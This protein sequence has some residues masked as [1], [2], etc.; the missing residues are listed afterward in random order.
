MKKHQYQTNLIW[1]GNLGVGT[2]NYAAYS[3]D[4]RLEVL[5]KAAI[6][7]SSDPAFKG[8][9]NKHNPEDL[10]VASISSC[11]MLWFLH[12]ASSKGIIVTD[13]SDTATGTMI[14]NENGSGYFDS[15]ILYPVVTITDPTRIDETNELH[16]LANK[17][18]FI[19]NSL[20]FKVK[21]DPICKVAAI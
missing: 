6:L 17:Y 13:Y 2:A 14:E 9:E 8:D 10:L 16:Q 4:Y 12:L 11:H 15:V 1:T 19:S 21:H 18:C 20:N 7:G 3:R 5:N